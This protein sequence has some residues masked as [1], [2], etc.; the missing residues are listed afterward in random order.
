MLFQ[1]IWSSYESLMKRDHWKKNDYGHFLTALKAFETER[2]L[3]HCFVTPKVFNPEK[4]HIIVSK[5]LIPEKDSMTCLGLLKFLTLTKSSITS[6][7]LLKVLILKNDSVKF[8]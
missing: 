6:L 8:L 3:H 5:F 4:R 2:E 7:R 1:D